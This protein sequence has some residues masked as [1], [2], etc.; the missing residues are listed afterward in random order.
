MKLS[1]C[2]KLALALLLCSNFVYGAIKDKSAIVYY[3]NDIS[4]ATVGIHDYIIVQ[5]EFI[6][7]FTHGF[8]VYKKKMYAYISVG[9]IHKDIKEFAKVKESWIVSKNK[10]WGSE[11]MDINNLEYQEF[12][13]KDVIEPRMKDGFENFFFDTLDSYY[14]YSK[15]PEEIKKSRDSLAHFINEFHK[16]Y[17]DSKLIINRGFEIIDQ[18]KDSI[19]A[20]LFESYYRSYGGSSGYKKVSDADREWLDIYLS[21]IKKYGIDIISVEYLPIEEMYKADELV[22]KIKAKGMIPYIATG[23]LNT[24]GRSNKNPIKREILTIIDENVYDRMLLG[25]HQYGALPLEYMGYIQKLR[26]IYKE[27]LPDLEHMSQYGGV[28]VWLRNPYSNPEKLVHWIKSVADSGIKVVFVNDFRMDL[29]K[30]PLRELGITT[31]DTKGS[32]LQKNTIKIQDEMIGF[33]VEPSKVMEMNLKSENVRPLYVLQNEN[34]QTSTLA[35]ITSW[36]GYAVGSSFLTEINGDNIW[37]INPFKFLKEALR[38]QDLV[39]PDPT[40]ENGNRIFFSHIDGDGIMN[41]VEWNPKLFSGETIYDGVLKKYGVPVSVSIVGAEVEPDGM[42]PKL[43][44]TL[45]NI[46]RKMFTL[47]NIEG[48]THTFSHPFQWN[49][50]KNGD[51]DKKYRLKVPNYKFDLDREILGSLEYVNENLMPKN[52]NKKLLAKSIFWTGDCRSTYEALDY[53]YRHHILNINAG[54]TFITNDY[55][56]L[57]GYVAPYG[58]GRGEYYQIYTGAQDEN[59]YT[60]NWTG[61][62]WG[63]KKAI[64]TFEL[65][66]SPRRVKPIDIYFHFYAGSKRASLKALQ[67]VFEWALKQ[68][69]LPLFTTEYIVKAMDYYTVSMAQEDDTWLISGMQNLHNLRIEKKDA[70]IDLKNSPHVT[71]FKHF[72]NHTYVSCD[73][74]EEQIIKTTDIKQNLPYLIDANAKVT[75]H[76]VA[77]NVLYLG[78]EGYVDLKLSLHVPKGCK[79][80]YDSKHAKMR[81]LKNSNVQLTYKNVKKEQ[82]HVTCR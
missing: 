30:E 68:D 6:N 50:I 41:R 60:N 63:Y 76:K 72:E 19:Q 49:K 58:V 22:K 75:K 81:K 47:D 23:D 21:K 46:A 8:S 78:F 57:G 71:G 51:L 34:N 66:N 13:F 70:K 28:V 36:G 33:E 43:S 14:M 48:A 53:T 29:Q 17:P 27:G 62:F 52:K 3:G 24:Y 74:S 55:P 32:P 40:T 44:P 38:L 77:N 9:E 26:D 61:P 10:S 67:D 79:V 4:Y 45:I 37:V 11:V 59:V 2:S 64:Q 18:V 42:Y 5:P 65:T 15:T 7:P 35:A 39:I 80:D 25:A 1:C 16:R 56:W 73:N 54:D 20:V 69:V 31:F 82:L 12:L